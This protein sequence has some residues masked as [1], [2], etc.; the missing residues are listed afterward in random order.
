MKPLDHVT[1]SAGRWLAARTSRRTFIANAG[2]A[3]VLAAGGSAL[4]GVFAMR[5]DARVCGQSGVSPKCPTFDCYAPDHWGWCWY[6]NGGCC[7]DGGIKKICDCCR[8]AHPNV[9]GYC[10]EGSNVFCIVESCL[11]DPRVMKVT[12]ERHQGATSVLLG[13]QRSLLSP[14][15]A[16][17]LVV[18]GDGDDPLMAAIAAPV[19]AELSAPLVLSHTAQLVDPV[20]AE[21]LR[22][23][24][25]RFLLVGSN[26][27][28]Q[29]VAD[30][31]ALGPVE[32]I[33]TSPGAAAASVEVAAWLIA[34][35]RR[36]TAF[37]L[38]AGSLSVS[39]AASVAAVAAL[40]R[41]PVL[42]APDAVSTVR[43]TGATFTTTFVSDEVGSPGAARAEGD[44]IVRGSDSTTISRT[45]AQ[46]ALD[47]EPR[48]TF[49]LVVMPAGG[50]VPSNGLLGSGALVLVHPDGVLDP[51]AR[52]WIEVNRAR[53]TRIDIA[54]D[55]PGAL[56]PDGVYQLQ[57]AANGFRSQLLIG[58][59]GQGIP[60][61][62]QP[63]EERP[64][65]RA[66]VS[67]ELPVAS[68][69]TRPPVVARVK[70]VKAK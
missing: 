12:V 1:E 53:F 18:I 37:C 9:H 8:D 30:L 69:T 26:H 51:V 11:E 61:V 56:P 40:R 13:L 39:V 58:T 3:A 45:I 43:A 15:R 57:S 48:A 23:G 52:D 27:S 22:L 36:S 4:A 68:S 25:T 60:V 70:P 14:A 50:A 55:A 33:G 41:A 66:R 24:A 64:V 44:T 34:R 42:I 2:R 47:A 20:R 54:T 35:Q 63:L 10:P 21:L 6:A 29:V 28:A 19:A 38:G 32:H 31:S 67:G 49:A 5:A 7:A 59:D 65:G 46:L 16:S 62:S 17:R